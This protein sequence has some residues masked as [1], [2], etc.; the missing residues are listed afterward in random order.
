MFEVICQGMKSINQ[1]LRDAFNKK[2]NIK[3]K[4]YSLSSDEVKWRVISIY[5]LDSHSI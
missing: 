4:Y 1:K 2:Q 3:I 5:K